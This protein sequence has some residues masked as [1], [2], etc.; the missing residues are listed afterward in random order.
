M[1]LLKNPK[2]EIFAQER[3]RGATQGVAAVAAGYSERTARTTG[4]KI[5]KCPSVRARIEELRAQADRKR[6]VQAKRQ[7]E[8]IIDALAMD[9]GWVLER[10]RRVF[11]EAMDNGQLAAANRSLELIGKEMGMFVDRKHVTTDPGAGMGKEEL[12]EAIQGIDKQL[13]EMGV[14][15]MID[16]TPGQ[17]AAGGG[18]LTTVE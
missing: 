11:Q 13:A 9:K 5:E 4:S 6:A 16:V 2:H 18:A 3:V 15:P 8:D 17:A 12:L 10:L 7:G 14:R 1:P